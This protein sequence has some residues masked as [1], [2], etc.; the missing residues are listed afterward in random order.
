MKGHIPP[1][2]PRKSWKNTIANNI[3]VVRV[4]VEIARERA[5]W[6]RAIKRIRAH[7]AQ[8]GNLPLNQQ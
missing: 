2:R 7:P 8:T 4:S 6:R 5:T 1:G 3:G